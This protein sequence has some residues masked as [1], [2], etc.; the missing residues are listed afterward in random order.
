MADILGI[1]V[2]GLSVSQ[3][4][5]KTAG[6]NISNAS[7]P[8]YSRQRVNIVP[9][10]EQ[11]IGV[12]YLGSGARV[13]DVERTVDQFYI[14]QLRAD[15]STFHELDVLSTQLGQLDS[16]LADQSTGL[17]PGL[18]QLFADLQ[19]A[20][21][22]PTSVPVRQVV[23]SDLGTLTQRFNTLY[24]Q[25]QAQSLNV[26]QSF[27]SLTTQVTGLAQ[28]I[29]K[30]NQKIAEEGGASGTPP[31]ALL[32]QRDELLRQLSEIVGVKT[33]TQSDGMVNVFIG[34]GQPL[35]IGNTASTLSTSPST[36]D[37]A[38][39][40]IQLLNGTTSADVTT[41]ISGGKLGGL[42]SFQRT[43]LSNVYNSLG[44][45]AIALTDALN[46]QNKLGID[47]NG[48]AG[49]NLLADINST[50]AMAA[51]VLRSATNTGSDRPSLMITDP[52]ALTT[53]DYQLI[54]TSATAYTVTRISDGATV[55]SSTLSGGQTTI[56]ASGSIDGFQIQISASPT[57][58][59]GDNFLLQPTKLGAQAVG[60]SAQTPQQLAFAQPIRTSTS[61]LNQGNGVIS[62]GVMVPEY[63]AA[64]PG[65]SFNVTNP[66][67]QP[68]LVRFTSATAYQIL[69]N[70]NPAAPAAFVPALTGTI[71][72]GQN[73]IVQI[74]DAAG[75]PVY[76]FTLA[77]APAAGDEFSVAQNAGGSSDNRNALALAGLSL[78]KIIGTLN[79]S[80][81]YGQMVSD[82]GAKTASAKN[83]RDA[84]NTLMTQ[85]QAN[86]DSVSA[87]NLDEEAAN[88][89]K[90]QQAYQASA[91]VIAAART[92]FDSLLAAFR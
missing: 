56:P 30:L 16:L 40:T 59:A 29:G 1:G 13:T 78:T 76:Q 74:N 25:L 57:F 41:L 55:L 81:A 7:T 89:I 52:S 9:Q 35:V 64:T 90:F 5:L 17:S 60:V 84:A 71:T 75:A 44:R 48:N 77:G 82:V 2:S 87:V 34:T 8:G 21:Q 32:D 91:Q 63:G 49:T 45:V 51:R 70:S 54:F 80:D 3:S 79:V 28:N 69:N 27:D 26:N 61:A 50:G 43:T 39:N 73:N 37:P 10:P 31:N 53:S 85:A 19:Q 11:Y 62:Q 38:Q 65:V 67:T 33:V 22:D 4:A 47:L 36:T 83:N 86:R 58:A 6:N 46:Q 23:L 20:S 88:L 24:A 92:L 14:G 42:V 68:L 18:Q 72:P 12:G 66:L 15:T